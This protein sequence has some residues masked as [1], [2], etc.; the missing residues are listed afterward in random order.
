MPQP[1]MPQPIYPPPLQNAVLGV[2][3][4]PLIPVM[5]MPMPNPSPAKMPLPTTLDK[6]SGGQLVHI[7]TA[8]IEGGYRPYSPLP[9]QATPQVQRPAMYIEFDAAGVVDLHG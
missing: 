2:Q 7:I 8:A 3:F 9:Q 5:P 4:P 1:P 6:M